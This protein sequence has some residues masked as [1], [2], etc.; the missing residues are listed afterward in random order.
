MTLVL[1]V[2]GGESIW[3]LADRRLSYAGRAPKDDA[4][5]VMVLD[6]TDGTAILGYAGL[7]ATALGTQPADWMSAVLRG[8]NLPLEQA[9]GVLADAMQRQL[10]KHLLKLSKNSLA[11]HAIYITA[12]L[13]NEPRLYTIELVFS[14]DRKS[15]QFGFTRWKTQ[16]SDDIDPRTPRLAVGGTGGIFLLNNQQWIRGLLD[17]VKA[18]DHRKVSAN[19]IADHLANLNYQ[20]HLG[21]RDKSVGPSCIIAWK[22]RKEG[23]FKGGGGHLTYTGTSRDQNTPSI[24]TIAGGFD[25]H[26]IVNEMMA[27]HLRTDFEKGLSELDKEEMKK[28]VESLPDQPDENLR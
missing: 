5:K 17:L 12:F 14:P 22:H 1:T 6:T 3:L 26:A 23:V 24:P 15:S 28:R 2:T 20:V 25:V 18:Y 11:A 21:V 8:Q 7:G 19:V 10:P 27:I 9:L 13:G 16:S 4:R